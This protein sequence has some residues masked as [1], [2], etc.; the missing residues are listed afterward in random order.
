[1]PKYRR[2]PVT[3]LE[4]VASTKPSGVTFLETLAT[5]LL[6]QDSS[7]VYSFSECPEASVTCRMFGCKSTGIAL[8]TATTE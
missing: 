3:I 8:F 2:R 6:K 5:S 4:S 1:V 7:V